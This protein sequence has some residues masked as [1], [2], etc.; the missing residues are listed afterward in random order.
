MKLTLTT[1]ILQ[2]DLYF[3]KLKPKSLHIEVSGTMCF[4]ALGIG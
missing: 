1:Y 2:Y 3:R 4:G